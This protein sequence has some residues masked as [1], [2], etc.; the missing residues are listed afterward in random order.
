M[1]E[2]KG[3]ANPEYKVIVDIPDFLAQLV[4]LP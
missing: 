4:Q 2:E 1:R 3:E